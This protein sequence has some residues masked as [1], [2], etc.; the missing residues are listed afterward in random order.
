[1]YEKKISST[2]VVKQPNGYPLERL[3]AMFSDISYIDQAKHEIATYVKVNKSI[4]N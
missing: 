2:K 1:M 4:T 3:V